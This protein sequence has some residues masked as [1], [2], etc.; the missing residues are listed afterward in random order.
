MAQIQVQRLHLRGPPAST[1][2]A[3]FRIEDALRTE[4]VD[5]GRFILIRRLA[6][7]PM[8]SGSRPRA[9]PDQL[10]GA[11]RRMVDQARHGGNDGAADVDC[12][13][14]RDADEARL[15]LVRLL[16]AGRQPRGWFW[17]LAVPDWRDR[18]L[19][20]WIAEQLRAHV[21]R[22]DGA[23]L[24]AL[25]MA[26]VAASATGILV[27]ALVTAIGPRPSTFRV[28]PIEPLAGVAHRA[29][30]DAGPGLAREADPDLW[31]PGTDRAAAY[32]VAT[33]LAAMPRPLLSAL[34]QVA[35]SSGTGAPLRMIAEAMIVRQRPELALSPGLRRGYAEEWVRQLVDPDRRRAAA[36]PLPVVAPSR[37]QEARDP[38]RSA[39]ERRG[40][41]APDKAA[42]LVP[43][44]MPKDAVAGAVSPA[45][46]RP[47]PAFEESQVDPE[48]FSAYAGLLLVIVP[49]IALGWRE[50]LADRE[51]L[52]GD[53][54]T[55]R[56]MHAVSRHYHVAED[57]PVAQLFTPPLDDNDATRDWLVAWR[58]GLDRWLRRQTRVRLAALVHRRGWIT[59]TEEGAMVR[60]P[61]EAA[62]IRLRRLALDRD[63]GWVD[64]LGMSV[65]F[66]Y[67]DRPGDAWRSGRQ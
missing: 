31:P 54:P 35:R 64:W 51:E 32:R 53:A 15:V 49:L 39:P 44:A 29:A 47:V 12:V 23:A 14:F 48:R 52:I 16:A 11:Y 8:A 41:P 4:V 3:A 38:G 9:F 24:T 27:D 1:G 5:D 33:L 37:A 34:A 45:S 40:S 57:D 63:P 19:E 21:A 20:E 58:I 2:R 42:T 43:A 17:K 26:L 50:W 25:V 22:A 62:D 28:S 67:R 60:F 18:P 36:T 59:R 65:R 13:W 61:V 30:S 6:L 7:G 66:A 46:D 10:A 56:L 55:A